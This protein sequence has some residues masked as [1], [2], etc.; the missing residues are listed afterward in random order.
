MSLQGVVDTFATRDGNGDGTYNV[1]RRA[2]RGYTSEGYA[3][4]ENP[5]TTLTPTMSVQP[6]GGGLKTLPEGRRVEDVRRIFT[7]TQ[8]FDGGDDYEPDVVTIGG[9]PFVVFD[10][11]GPWDLDGFNHY[12][13][14][15]ARQ[16]PTGG[17]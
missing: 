17:P 10:V 2:K 16:R 7:E 6:M 4:A 13:V 12:E 3:D 8:L 1:T 15:A 14:L 5:A 11:A 9:E